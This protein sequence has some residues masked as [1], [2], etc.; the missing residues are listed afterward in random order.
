MAGVAEEDH[1][2]LR[3]R[4][5]T[6][7]GRA[8]IALVSEVVGAQGIDEDEN[9]IEATRAAFG[10]STTSEHADPDDQ[11]AHHAAKKSGAASRHGTHDTTAAREGEERGTPR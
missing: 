9:Q 2:I 7:R 1:R 11:D 6:R 10:F 8:R 3:E 4:I 5:Q